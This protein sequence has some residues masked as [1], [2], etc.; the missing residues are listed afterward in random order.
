MS[1]WHRGT[2]N[3]FLGCFLS[4][5]RKR[6]YGP[7]YFSIL[8]I[9]GCRYYIFLGE[10]TF[11]SEHE[12][13]FGSFSFT[14]FIISL[15]LS[16]YFLFFY[17]WIRYAGASETK[18]IGFLTEFLLQRGRGRVNTIQGRAGD[19]INMGENKINVI[20]A[21]E[22]TTLALV[23]IKIQEAGDTG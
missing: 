3:F 14:F 19:L 15:S 16:L 17:R 18:Y 11:F 4:F 5:P 22:L 8:L 20:E 9:L 10:C 21:S 6:I 13:L 23:A 1:V 12:Y 7:F 2:L